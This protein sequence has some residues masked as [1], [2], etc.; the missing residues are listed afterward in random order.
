MR[1]TIACLLALA[2]IAP[3]LPAEARFDSDDAE[4]ACDREARSEYDAYDIDHL[5]VIRQDRGRFTVT[6]LAQRR[7]RGDV[8]FTCTYE[9]G[10]VT[11][12]R[13]DSGGSGGGSGDGSGAAG[14]VAGAVLGAVL[15]GAI[16]RDHKSGDHRRSDDPYDHDSNWDDD[17]SPADG[18]TCYRGQRACYKRN[19][20]YAPRWTD[21]EFR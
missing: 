20:A 21:R 9:S 10:R 5:H 18:I 7:H 6:G 3:A 13:S 11:R 2:L 1:R 15:L 4:R 19:G 17:Y 14:I 16:A 12:L 8:N